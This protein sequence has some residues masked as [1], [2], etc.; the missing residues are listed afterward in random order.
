MITQDQRATLQLLLERDQSYADLAS[1]LGEDEAAVRARARAALTELVGADPDRNVGLTD[2]LLGQADPIGR[3][4]ASRHLRD[5]PDDNQLATELAVR[6]RLMFPTAEL[7]RLPGEARQSSG[8]LRRSAPTSGSSGSTAPSRASRLG[9]GGL[10]RSQSRLI[11]ICASGAL[12]LIVIV[13]AITGAFSGGDDS[14]TDTEAAGSTSTTAANTDN[15]LQSV[16]LKPIGGGDASG[17][18]VF[19]LATG[20]QPYVDLTIKGLDPAPNDQTYVAWLMLTDTKGYPLTPLV[21]ISQDGAYHD[22]LPIPQAVLPVI[23]RTQFVDVSI[24]P[25]KTI[26][27]IV[28]GAI[29]NTELVIDEPGTKV[30]R[31]TI[32]AG[33]SQS[34]GG[35]SGSGTGGG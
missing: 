35:G 6:L 15:V 16:D 17:T 31:G 33:Q 24:A 25:V 28:R 22:R 21:G 12:L 30:L 34:Q 5:D 10:D 29:K 20:D 18:A 3:A 8:L 14:S 7:P 13:L 26:R 19:G 1:L 4:D 27:N 23:A 2:Y 9:F 11:V 32:P